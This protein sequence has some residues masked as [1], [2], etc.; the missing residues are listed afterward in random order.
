MR[1]DGEVLYNF[2]EGA[3]LTKKQHVHS[4][5]SVKQLSAP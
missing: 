4:L 1:K 2:L 3:G 5:Q